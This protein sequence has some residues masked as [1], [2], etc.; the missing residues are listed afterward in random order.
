MRNAKCPTV[1]MDDV[2]LPEVN[3]VE[4]LGKHLDRRLIW[5]SILQQKENN[6]ISNSAKHGRRSQLTIENKLLL[7]TAIMK[8]IWTYGVE[9]WGTASNSNIEIL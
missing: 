9:L 7:Y 4:C 1:R 3:K 8:P 6:S 5:K 2:S